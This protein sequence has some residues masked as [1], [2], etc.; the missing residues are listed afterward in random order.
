MIDVK[1]KKYTLARKTTLSKCFC[2]LCQQ[3]STKKKKKNGSCKGRV[4][5]VVPSS[6]GARLIVTLTGSQKLSLFEEKM[7]KIQNLSIP[8]NYSKCSDI[9]SIFFL[10]GNHFSVCS[11]YLQNTITAVCKQTRHIRNEDLNE[12]QKKNNLD[13]MCPKIKCI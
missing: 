4:L 11:D 3:R 12:M 5:R 8:L 9:A 7:A 13:I 10:P 1:G 6:E 2:L